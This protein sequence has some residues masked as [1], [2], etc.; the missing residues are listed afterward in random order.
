V[1]ARSYP[2]GSRGKIIG[3]PDQG[4]HG[5]SAPNNW[6]SRNAD[7]IAVPSGTPVYAVASGTIG[8]Q[9]GSL[10]S[11]D[12]K[13]AG[14]RVHLVTTGN[15]FYYAHLSKLVVS[16]GQTV[17]AGQLLGYSGAATGVEHLHCASKKGDPAAWLGGQ[18]Q[19]G[20]SAP[21]DQAAPGAPVAAVA[22][23]ADQ[24]GT[25]PSMPDATAVAPPAGPP[26]PDSTQAYQPPPGSGLYAASEGQSLADEW[27]RIASQPGSDPQSQ[28][29]ASNAALMGG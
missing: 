13:M 14:L 22:P 19:G 18:P 12:P 28:L 6:E 2:L 17:T 4:T 20:A 24:T 5:K 26:T 29:L 27:N 16:A 25:Q 3:L 9:I 11:T 8:S 7:D 15:E 1:A 23:V 10:D 21:Q